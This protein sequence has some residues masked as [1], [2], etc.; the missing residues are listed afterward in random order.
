MSN[1]ILSYIIFLV[2]LAVTGALIYTYI[3]TNGAERSIEDIPVE[4]IERAKDKELVEEVKIEKKQA[5]KEIV[6]VDTNESN[7]SKSSKKDVNKSV[8]VSEG[9]ISKEQNKT[10]VEPEKKPV[11]EV[12]KTK[13]DTNRT[14]VGINPELVMGVDTVPIKLHLNDDNDTNGTFFDINVSKEHQKQT[15]IAFALEKSG[16]EMGNPVFIRIFKS[17]Y[18]L[19]VWMKMAKDSN[20]TH[21]KT[22]PICNYSG[23]LGPKLKEGDKQAPEGFYEITKN[24]L[25]PNSKFHLSMNIGYPNRYDRY[26]GRT[27]S[28]IMIHGACVSIGCFAMGDKQIEEIYD[29]VESALDNGQK[30][31]KVHIFPFRMSEKEMRLHSNNR[32]Y[33]F[34]ENLK[35]GYDYFEKSHKIPTVG[36]KDGNYTFK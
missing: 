1:K 31:V 29:L 8:L 21:L 26:Y 25:N 24:S 11:V 9:N 14:V 16:G 7:S 35:E 5:K 13:R 32:W 15:P 27:G 36:L 28:Y 2:A 18:Q 30:S 23:E 19:E 10:E 33:E 20:Y 12:N 34:W 22:Y 6:K 4:H 17:V 3:S